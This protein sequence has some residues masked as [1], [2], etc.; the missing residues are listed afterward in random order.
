M[1][2]SDEAAY[3]FLGASVTIHNNTVIAGAPAPEMEFLRTAVGA[4]VFEL[5]DFSGPI[6]MPS[7]GPSSPIAASPPMQKPRGLLLFFVSNGVEWIEQAELTA[8]D[9]VTYH[10]LGASIAIDSNTVIAGA[11]GAE[12]ETL[13]TAVGAYLFELPDFTEPTEAPSTVPSSPTTSNAPAPAIGTTNAPSIELVP[14]PTDESTTTTCPESTVCSLDGGISFWMYREGA[15]Y[16]FD[17]RPLTCETECVAASWV[18][19]FGRR[20]LVLRQLL[21]W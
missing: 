1:T 18:C 12:G 2:A 20:R 3:H 19:L 13:G 5:P 15:P 17:G 21:N 9:G 8:S 14:L 4:Y 11:P 16:D 10:F 6:V 7:K